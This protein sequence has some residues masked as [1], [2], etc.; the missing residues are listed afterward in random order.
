[1][2][3]ATVAA[4]LTR[5]TAP[6]AGPERRARCWPK[7]ACRSTCPA[8]LQRPE[9]PRGWMTRLPASCAGAVTATASRVAAGASDGEAW[10]LRVRSSV[11]LRGA[12]GPLSRANPIAATNRTVRRP[13]EG[14][15]GERHEVKPADRV[16][17]FQSGWTIPLAA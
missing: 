5:P 4:T 1:M 10:D 12:Y 8:L 14:Y 6:D 15:G 9:L 13:A 11:M 7:P 2:P 3:G 17:S 16:A